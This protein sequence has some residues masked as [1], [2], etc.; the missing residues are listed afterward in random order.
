MRTEDVDAPDDDWVGRAQ[1]GDAQAF[2]ILFDRYYDMIHAFAYRICL[3]DSEAEDL[4]QETFIRAA[5]GIGSYRGTASFKN[6]LFSIAHHAIIDWQRQRS[7]RR[8]KEVA[9]AAEMESRA[10]VRAPD[11]APVHAALAQLPTDWREAVA[12]VYFEEMNH[13]D[14]A[15]VVGCAETTLS[16]RIFR[17]KRALKKILEA[18]KGGLE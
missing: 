6:W 17:A 5:R 7:R 18:Q 2:E 12:L 15:N 13:R 8:D 10:A 1:D 11:H 4:A 9:F 14:A 3:A 16:W